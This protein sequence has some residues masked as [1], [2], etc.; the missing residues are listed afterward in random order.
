MISKNFRYAKKTPKKKIPPSLLLR[1][2][3]AGLLCICL[4]LSSVMGITSMFS[5]AY[6]D[7]PNKGLC[8]HHPQHT[9]DCGYV[10]AVAGQ[11][12]TH[13]HE[14][15][16]GYAEEI[17]EVP[18]DQA[19]P[20]DENDGTVTHDEA[21]AY[22]PAVPASPCTHVHD[23][24]CGYVEPLQGQPC[25]FVCEA[26]ANQN[27][28]DSQNQTTPLADAPIQI[29]SWEWVTPEQTNVM[30]DGAG[31]WYIN[32]DNGNRGVGNTPET[33]TWSKD[34]LEECLPTAISVTP[35]D[36][37]EKI[38]IDL[39]WTFPNDFK[40]L[41]KGQTTEVSPVLPE[42]FEKE[43][44]GVSAD[45][46]K[47]TIESYRRGHGYWS[48]D[49][50][51]GAK[52]GLKGEGAKSPDEAPPEGTYRYLY[53][54]TWSTGVSAEVME[55]IRENGDDVTGTSVAYLFPST[56]NMV[57]ALNPDGT[58]NKNAANYR[59]GSLKVEWSLGEYDEDAKSYTFVATLV[60]QEDFFPFEPDQRATIVLQE[61]QP[62]KITEVE[63]FYP[64][65][66]PEDERFK[67]ERVGIGSNSKTCEQLW[68]YKKENIQ[69]LITQAYVL[70]RLPKEIEAT[71]DIDGNGTTM[72]QPILL[73]WEHDFP[74]EGAYNGEYTFTA[75]LP[76][77]FTVLDHNDFPRDR[78]SFTLVL[79][80]AF[81]PIK[82]GDLEAHTVKD[83]VDP[84]DA[85]VNLFDYAAWGDGAKESDLPTFDN[86]GKTPP[87]D[88]PHVRK[89][90]AETESN[91]VYR[92]N[93]SWTLGQGINVGRL[94]M[95]GDGLIH[96]GL[97]NRGAGQTTSYGK[98]HAN[99]TK[100]VESI[101]DEKGFPTVN[102]ALAKEQLNGQDMDREETVDS[103]AD[104]IDDWDLTGDHDANASPVY[105]HTSKY[106][107]NISNSV[108]DAWKNSGNTASLDYLFSTD[109]KT[110]TMKENGTEKTI[111]RAYENVTGLFQIDDEGYYTYDMRKNYAEF[112][113][114][115]T[116]KEDVDGRLSDGRFILYNA[117][118]ILRTDGVYSIGNFLPFN[119]ADATNN[120]IDHRKIPEVFQGVGKTSGQ[121]VSTENAENGSEKANHHFGMTVEVPFRQPVGGNLTQGG[122]PMS[123]QF[124]GDDDVW[125][126]LDDVLVLDIGGIHSDLYGTID[127]SNG[128]IYVGRGFDT[129]G[130]PD[131][132]ADPDHMY[133]KHTIKEMFM[134]ARADA[135]EAL[136]NLQEGS[137]EYAHKQQVIEKID[138]IT[139]NG[140]TFS[141][142]SDHTL[143]MF[144][145]ERG[146]Y[147]SSL[148]LRFNLLPRLNQQ[149]KKVDQ[150]GQPLENVAFE[151][152][153]ATFAKKDDPDAVE[154]TNNATSD[155]V[156]TAGDEEESEQIYLKPVA[157]AKPCASLK[158]DTDG[159]AEFKKVEEGE[160]PGTFNFAEYLDEDGKIQKYYIL[161]ETSTPDGYRK[162]P[163]DLALGYD[164]H[165]G[166]LVVV[167]RWMTGAYAGFTST[168]QGNRRITYGHF[169]PEI[170]EIQPDPT[171]PVSEDVQK[172]GLV[173]AVPML[174]NSVEG[175]EGWRAIYGSNM[176]NFQ[177][178]NPET[179]DISGLR[180]QDQ[181]V[182]RW[183]Q[184]V[185]EAALYQAYLAYESTNPNDSEDLLTDR[186]VQGWYLEWDHERR[187][188]Q[189]LGGHLTDLP[190][191]PDRYKLTN[192][193]SDDADMQ[194][195]YG[196]ID[197]KALRDLQIPLEIKNDE[198]V[199]V[200]TSGEGRYLAL[201]KIIYDRVK[202]G[203]S[204]ANVVKQIRTGIYNT[205]EISDKTPS[206]SGFT[207][208]NVDEFS[209]A[210][211]SLVYIPNEQRELRVKKIDQEGNAVDG[212]E[213][214]LY[215]DRACTQEVVSGKTATVANQEG[216]LI[217]T[218]QAA[219]TN[220]PD[221][222][223]HVEWINPR[224]TEAGTMYYLKE[225]APANGNYTINETVVPVVVGIY[226]IY[227]DAGTA[228]DG[229]S[230][231]AGVGK[232]AQT[233]GQYASDGEVNITLRDITATAQTQPSGSF[234]L[235]GWKDITL[236]DS[237]VERSMDLHYG[238]NAVVDYGLHDADGGQTIQPFFVTD[239]G[240][241]RARVQQNSDAYTGTG[242]YEGTD[243]NIRAEHSDLKGLNIT[244][245]FSLLNTV[246]VSNRDDSIT[247]DPGELKIT[248]KVIGEN[249]TRD[250]YIRNFNFTINLTQADGSPLSGKYYFHG[251]DKAGYIDCDA[252]DENGQRV[253]PW[254]PLHHDESITIQGLPVGTRFTVTE[255]DANE[256]GFYC[257][258][259][260][261]RVTGTITEANVPRLTA[262]GV[263]T[264]NPAEAE[265]INNKGQQPG[266][267]SLT[268]R[269][270]VEGDG[271]DRNLTFRFT[272]TLSGTT[273]KAMY[274]GRE[275]S[276]PGS[277][278]FRLR[279]GERAT[280]TRIP[281]GTR[282][283]VS[284]SS[285]PD[286]KSS[287]EDGSSRGTIEDQETAWVDFVN[288]KKEEKPKRLTIRKAVLGNQGDLN[289]E[290][291]FTVT[292]L[293]A[294]RNPLGGYYEYS[295]SYTGTLRS[296]DTIT[297]K[298]GEWIVIDDLPEDT[299]YTVTEREANQDGYTTT[300]TGASGQIQGN[301]SVSANFTNQKGDVPPPDDPPP[302]SEDDPPGQDNPPPSSSAPPPPSEDDPPGQDNPPGNH[303]PPSTPRT[304]DP[305]KTIL[306]VVMW[307][308][309]LA[310]L[311]VLFMTRKKANKHK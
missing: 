43:Y 105:K 162:L 160:N 264:S 236:A 216:I 111:K 200:P 58:P 8:E 214:T 253:L 94:L 301:R 276:V 45:A 49:R 22:H 83:T 25:A 17:P 93:N 171:H 3:T 68:Y 270:S 16:C 204:L 285:D 185:L 266:T 303:N 172:D 178:V 35:A 127:F 247:N 302:P 209:R 21:C 238:I 86:T 42:E 299:R 136:E 56:I 278:T 311:I 228:T 18:C 219:A 298:D 51:D 289:K 157:G 122:T 70:E 275:Y 292:L 113:K 206:G 110:V 131:N 97:W 7:D 96:A 218:P 177:T 29:A 28:Q 82:P 84:P 19:C 244:S 258:P 226:S 9:A 125:V 80:E 47:I 100:I 268:V 287:V 201:G 92:Y 208:L 188:E 279:D 63:W 196:V 227:A 91:R 4:V 44:N 40:E 166:T 1:R 217:F 116:Q 169:N 170:G 11:S 261:G 241:L 26:C 5:I 224:G 155:G 71:V 164:I 27:Q 140:E 30:Q 181:E 225:T 259:E 260:S 250:D 149:V 67:F 300:S 52:F 168:I 137:E 41:A 36:S 205:K 176:T 273:G 150:Y 146:N 186:T 254:I 184:S 133:R 99:M 161:K 242:K 102:I 37:D 272:V 174:Y 65:D 271:A 57:S 257:T 222:Y 139:F 180:E 87:R 135:V 245:L 132:P 243:I 234:N 103:I 61:F 145:L 134:A 282:Y 126:F 210:F 48:L 211:R 307:V 240:F 198:G 309:S 153:P 235:A 106:I 109:E 212:A 304:G 81:D 124:S 76:E 281:V 20:P 159:I 203:E 119:P 215:S 14:E 15:T 74:E 187:G 62:G 283:S 190:G 120:T 151:L 143:K 89:G 167:N 237:P 69:E 64:E 248:K 165:R 280:I 262:N 129:H 192:K 163:V 274:D 156:E 73:D 191:R 265:F 66:V 12:C 189:R 23:A 144:Y 78:I 55:E 141:D 38:E 197:P 239:T 75:K 195:V 154:C 108:F 194:M 101:L 308:S 123:F 107:Q 31:N 305:T 2:G 115:D 175:H 213:F 32:K 182:I 286:Y 252:R 117:P 263:F 114:Y 267:G 310:A 295:G 34:K 249:L 147:D 13:V 288:E 104:L 277:I 251:T 79:R 50:P 72:K 88:D 138:S 232:L 142:N 54:T 95:F 39:S 77:G 193:T 152:Y 291:H 10:L 306:W 121:L 207:F 33:I 202:A 128:N 284:E 85:I 255:T 179:I 173:V 229:V 233:M 118:G 223:A 130:I 290:F 24:Q 246:V 220:T 46:L 158:T 296:G 230:V 59:Q 183:R 60:N 148:A 6:A 53:D 269:K 256:D 221:G 199:V 293:D 90:E 297:L 231:M 294:D 112:Y 98:T